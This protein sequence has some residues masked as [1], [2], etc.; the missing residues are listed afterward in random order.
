MLGI[1]DLKLCLEDVHTCTC[2][3]LEW[4]CNVET[5]HFFLERAGL[6]PSLSLSLQEHFF[7][8]ALRS[9]QCC[10]WKHPLPFTTV[11]DSDEMDKYQDSW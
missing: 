3:A 11:L 2:P 7:L 4:D 5:T 10:S 9:H 8:L 6:P 1:R